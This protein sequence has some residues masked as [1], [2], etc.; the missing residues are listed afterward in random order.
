MLVNFPLFQFVTGTVNLHKKS[1]FYYLIISHKV[2]KM[3][4]IQLLR[5]KFVLNAQNG[6]NSKISRYGDGFRFYKE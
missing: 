2:I 6:K 1:L 3:I 5:S 4:T